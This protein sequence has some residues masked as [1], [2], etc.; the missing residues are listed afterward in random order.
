MGE[1]SQPLNIRHS[2]VSFPNHV[3]VTRQYAMILTPSTGLNWWLASL[4]SCLNSMSFYVALPARGLTWQ[5]CRSQSPSVN[6]PQEHKQV[7]IATRTTSILRIDRCL[8]NSQ[9][10]ARII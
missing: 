5:A 7:F 10:K 4:Q 2:V 1:S 6:T 3:P 8:S 9:P